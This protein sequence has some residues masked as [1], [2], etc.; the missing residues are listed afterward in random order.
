MYPEPGNA[1]RAYRLAVVR[2]VERLARE[3]GFKARSREERMRDEA[4]ARSRQLSLVW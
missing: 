2:R 3:A 4:P 1:P